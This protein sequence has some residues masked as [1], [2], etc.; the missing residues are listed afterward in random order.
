[1]L[2]TFSSTYN[3]SAPHPELPPMNFFLSL[4]VICL[5]SRPSSTIFLMF[6]IIDTCLHLP[7]SVFILY[8]GLQQWRKTSTSSATP[9]SHSDCFTY[10]LAGMELIGVIG[11]IVSSCAIYM[12]N[13][14]FLQS[15]ILIYSITWF[16]EMCFH[17]LTCVEHYLAVVHPIIYLNLRNERWIR[18][19]TVITGFVWLL[20]LSWV[21][22]VTVKHFLVVIF[23]FVIFCLL[24]VSFCNFSVLSV[25]IR[26]GPGGQGGGRER[27]D[28]SKRRAFYTIVAILGTLVL[29]FAWGL[30]WTIVYVS[31][32]NTDCV[33]MTVDVW[34]SLPSS[35]MLP[36]LFLYRTGRC[37]FCKKNIP[38]A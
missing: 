11:Y 14:L 24:V 7:L 28:Q 38:S 15:S 30:F 8:H 19:R 22:L 4:Y 6:V 1:M 37:L 17:M 2:M 10:H 23:C 18:I 27:A 12:E 35:L 21:I 32:G 5:V 13:T 29:R 34:F 25:L 36:L 16:G 31:K 3:E 26:P 9:I 33:T 20:C